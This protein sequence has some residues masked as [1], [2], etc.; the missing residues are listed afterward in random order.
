M[1]PQQNGCR[2]AER[3]RC[4][5]RRRRAG[6]IASWL[7]ALLRRGNEGSA[8]LAPTLAG[9]R[10]RQSPLAV[11]DKR[12]DG[13]VPESSTRRTHQLPSTCAATRQHAFPIWFQAGR[14]RNP[15]CRTTI[16]PPPKSVL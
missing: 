6:A 5:T 4:R 1:A 3:L 15:G 13:M 12:P 9:R 2:T 7:S 14:P 16:V 10:P 8:G 11:D